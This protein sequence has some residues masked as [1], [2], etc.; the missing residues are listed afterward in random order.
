MIRNDP[1]KSEF[2]M[3]H[4]RLSRWRTSERLTSL[5]NGLRAAFSPD[6]ERAFS[7][8]GERAFHRTRLLRIRQVGPLKLH[9]GTQ[10]SMYF[11]VRSG[12][13]DNSDPVYGRA[14][15]GVTSGGETSSGGNASNC[16][17]GGMCCG[18]M[19]TRVD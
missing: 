18:G 10:E 9:C 1:D 16:R 4:D 8:D 13:I 11:F 15:G 14:E 5:R 6:G 19:R 12:R 17:Q 3:V 2:T 7:P